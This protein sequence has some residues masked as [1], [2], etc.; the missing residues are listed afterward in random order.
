MCSAMWSRGRQWRLLCVCHSALQITSNPQQTS[1]RTVITLVW[2][3][4]DSIFSFIIHKVKAVNH[5]LKILTYL[6]KIAYVHVMENIYNQ[7]PVQM[8]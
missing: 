3:Q 5:H 6:I 7:Q 8:P 2:D 4:G 1:R